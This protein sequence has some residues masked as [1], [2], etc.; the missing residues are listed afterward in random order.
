MDVDETT[1]ASDYVEAMTS[2][3]A[4]KAEPALQCGYELGRRAIASGLGLLDVT[5]VHQQALRALIGTVTSPRKSKDLIQSA[6]LFLME[7][8]SP[9]EATHRGFR[10]AYDQ[11]KALNATLENRNAELNAINDGIKTRERQL[12]DAQR[13]AQ[14]G[15]WEWD[16]LSDQVTM[17]S[18]LF[19]I[20]GIGSEESSSITMEAYLNF[21]HPDDRDRRRECMAR[22]APFAVEERIV[23]P[24]G[25]VRILLSE[26]DIILDKSGKVVRMVGYSQ[27][28]TERR[29]TEL[30]LRESKDHYFQLFQQARR[31]EEH[32]RQL[33]KKMLHVQEEE[34]TRISRE[35]HDEVGQTL[36]AINMNLTEL[37][38]RISDNSDALVRRLADS[39]QLL[40]SSMENIHRFA[41]ELRPAM[42]DD[43]GLIPALQ[44]YAKTFAGRTGIN[45]RCQISSSIGKLDDMRNTVIYRIVQECFNNIAKH[46]R[47]QNVR[48]SI[49]RQQRMIVLQVKDDGR[50]FPVQQA[51]GSRRAKR[52]GLLG[53]LERSKLVGGDLTVNSGNGKGTT[54]RAT[55]P[56][57]RVSTKKITRRAVSQ[58]QDP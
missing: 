53:M 10:E 43:L 36:T 50:G 9:F 29:Q 47:A 26:A 21:V 5:K 1:L 41:R 15:S 49:S 11:L 48:L 12:A 8:L 40:E 33:S 18:E 45:L 54:V 46:A 13:L 24:D 2:F 52:L 42:L 30:A 4:D 35:L 23:R 25:K 22:A 14:L 34:R 6:G 39:Q 19:R 37:R 56:L 28:I 3:L 20:H 7:V 44:S 55:I 51:T 16:A 31:M 27:D 57:K 17:S 38:G 32:L 58:T